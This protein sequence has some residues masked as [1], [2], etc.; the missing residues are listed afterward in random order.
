MSGF[1]PQST[2]SMRILY[3][4]LVYSSGVNAVFIV[5]RSFPRSGLMR[6]KS[7]GTRA[8]SL[9]MPAF[10]RMA[11]DKGPQVVFGSEKRA[12]FIRTDICLLSS[13]V[14]AIKKRDA[15]YSL[16]CCSRVSGPVMAI[17][18]FTIFISI[19][20]NV[21]VG[22]GTRVGVNV[23]VGMVVLVAVAVDVDADVDVD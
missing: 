19:A 20:V 16:I 11:I 22:E 3:L 10:C 23:A 17:S 4:V 7:C 15:S 13:Y 14:G 18:P 12:L 5:P 2:W 9:M 1:V 8:S 21:A 6:K